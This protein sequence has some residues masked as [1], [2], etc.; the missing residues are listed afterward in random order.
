L[1]FDH[2]CKLRLGRSFFRKG[3]L[4]PFFCAPFPLHRVVEP[5]PQHPQLDL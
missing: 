3:F 1:I 2:P 5:F 4:C